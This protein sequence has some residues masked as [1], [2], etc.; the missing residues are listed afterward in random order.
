MKIL[1][2]ALGL[3]LL[4][5]PAAAQE[6]CIP[7]G[8]LFER[9]QASGLEFEDITDPVAVRRIAAEIAAHTEQPFPP[10][11]RLIIAFIGDG[12]KIGIVVNDE[13]C[14]VLSGPA[15]AVRMLLQAVHGQSVVG[16]PI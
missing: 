14:A 7:V 9:L 2:M 5:L 8:P 13:V 6:A 4:A 12:A 15:H 16:E 10:P 1:I 3:V 11:T